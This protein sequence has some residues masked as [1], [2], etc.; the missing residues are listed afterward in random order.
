MADNLDD[1]GFTPASDL[2]VQTIGKVQTTS[3]KF[4]SPALVTNA[5]SPEALL[6]EWRKWLSSVSDEAASCVGVHA[7]QERNEQMMGVPKSLE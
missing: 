3:Y 1:L 6:V 5:V 7:E 4:P 2:T